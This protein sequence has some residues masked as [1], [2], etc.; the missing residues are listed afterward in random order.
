MWRVIGA[1]VVGASHEKVGKGCDDASG[2]L[3][4]P[5]LTWL[6]VADGAGSRPLSAHGSRLA[7][8][9]VRGLAANLVRMDLN[10][11]P[12]LWLTA[13][14]QEVRRKLAELATAHG[15]EIQ[16]FATT[17]AVAVLIGDTVAI[18]QVGDTIA[19][20]GSAGKYEAVEPAPHFE[21]ANETVFVTHE[22]V[23]QH[24]RLAQRPAAEV[25]E[26]YLS[27][28]GL[29]FKI[30]DSL[31]TGAPYAPFFQ[32]AGAYARTPDADDHSIESFLAVLDDQSGDDKSL[33][34]GVRLT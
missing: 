31:A 33:V 9:T 21:Y 12:A 18:A 29:R 32:D 20:V 7:V 25:D 8:E 16:D 27:T 17:L 14:F 23:L 3:A 26:I 11:E 22:E 2:W 5:Q 24:V 34:I 4:E 30:L 15:T 28:D 19:V 6:A 13:V 10:P 1:S